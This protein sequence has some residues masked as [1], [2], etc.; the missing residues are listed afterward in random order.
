MKKI[1]FSPIVLRFI[2]LLFLGINSYGLAASEINKKTQQLIDITDSK[3]QQQYQ[4]SDAS[5]IN[6]FNFFWSQKHQL[7]T[8]NKSH[9]QWRYQ[10]TVKDKDSLNKWVYDPQGFARKL[11]LQ[12]NSVVYKF[13]SPRAFNRFLTSLK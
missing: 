2:T 6:R 12:K 1:T 4:L 3:L 11:S 10:L 7:I 9:F 8:Q 13:S 5:S